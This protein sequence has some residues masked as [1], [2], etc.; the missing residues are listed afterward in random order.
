MVRLPPTF[1][2]ASSTQRGCLGDEDHAAVIQNEEEGQR[3]PGGR[4]IQTIRKLSSSEEF[5]LFLF[6]I[7]G[8]PV[9]VHNA[10]RP[11]FGA[12][13]LPP[14]WS[15]VEV[16]GAAQE[17]PGTE[18]TYLLLLLGPLPPT[19]PRLLS[20]SPREAESHLSVCKESGG[21]VSSEDLHR[22]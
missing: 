2:K 4:T 3:C 22:V 16:T 20:L 12:S 18:T 11:V 14:H 15:H 19:A 8:S 5:F 6:S 1:P 13:F 17:Q 9:D 21:S 10:S 7:L